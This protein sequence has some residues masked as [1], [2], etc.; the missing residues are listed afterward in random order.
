[1]NQIVKQVLGSVLA[2]QCLIGENPNWTEVLGT[3]TAT[4]NLQMVGVNMM[5]LLL[6]WCMAKNIIAL[7]CAPRRRFV[8]VGQYQSTFV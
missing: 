2:E 7:C 3:V 1:M 6:K 8:S 5:C 4:I